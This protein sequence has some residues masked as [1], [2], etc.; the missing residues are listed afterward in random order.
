M[1]I[2]LRPHHLLCT[3]G[4][5]GNG[6]SKEFVE[7]MNQI[8]ARLRSHEPVKIRL[9][10]STDDLCR[11]CPNMLAEGLC[12]TDDKVTKFDRKIVAYFDLKEQDYIYQ[13]IVTEIQSKITPE[14]LADI[15]EGC[16]WYPVSACR[17]KILKDRL[18]HC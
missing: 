12:R 5:Q 13:D 16:G 8:T 2:K 4:Y 14:I 9:V 11:C 10:F 1:D 7:N 18:H 6:Y 15:C 17:E 3:Q